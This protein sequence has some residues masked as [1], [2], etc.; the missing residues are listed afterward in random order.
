MPRELVFRGPTD[1]ELQ[2]VRD[3][4]QGGY[5]EGSFR[6]FM[7]ASGT[8][9]SNR[10]LPL[11]WLQAAFLTAYMILREVCDIR[12]QRGEAKNVRKI[13]VAWCEDSNEASS[14][15]KLQRA[16]VRAFFSWFFEFGLGPLSLSSLFRGEPH[17]DGTDLLK[18][19]AKVTPF[20]VV[21][22]LQLHPVADNGSD[23]ALG[24]ALLAL[25]GPA[26]W[27]RVGL[28]AGRI[29]S[30]DVAHWC[31]EHNNS[32]QTAAEIDDFVKHCPVESLGIITQ[33]RVSPAKS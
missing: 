4:F 14:M 23:V 8:R 19:K 24:E 2:K 9:S 27:A 17:Q 11:E 33:I 25:G 32:L 26:T 21:M 3:L 22:G 13:K 28:I 10:Q 6:T 1:A 30:M 7:D 5:W 31:L 18:K 15:D 20:R 16:H 12:K 29:R